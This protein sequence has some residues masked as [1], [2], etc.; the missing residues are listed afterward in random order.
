VPDGYTL[1]AA[2][3]SLVVNPSLY[4]AVPFD[5][6]RDFDPVTILA[7]AP[8]V[9]TVHPSVPAGTFEELIALIRANPGR[10]SYASPGTGTPPHLVGEMFRLSLGLDLVHVAYNSGGL[11]IGSTVAGHT[12]VSFGALPPAVP[13][14]REGRLRALAIT[15]GRRSHAL[16]DIPTTAEAGHPNVAGDIWTAVLLPTGTPREIAAQ[17]HRGIVD[18]LALPEVRDRLTSLGYEP[19]GNSAEACAAQMRA[20]AA[21]W[22]G[23][24]RDAGIRAQ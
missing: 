19:V 14:V 15:S 16:P 8:T 11:A 12:P 4:D 5:A 21:K 22:A 23:L 3:P 13:H 2:A 20:E 18:A 1:L 17:L 7:S 10:Y 6:G 9:L 24:I